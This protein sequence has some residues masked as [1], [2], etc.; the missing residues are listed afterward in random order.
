MR[1]GM[2]KFTSYTNRLKKLPQKRA[3]FFQ[4]VASVEIRDLRMPA[5]GNYVRTDRKLTGKIFDPSLPAI[6]TSD[7]KTIRFSRP[8]NQV[9]TIAK[10]LLEDDEATPGEVGE[11]CFDRVMRTLERK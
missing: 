5:R 9:E 6:S 4:G 1:E 10:R 3:E 8:A 7:L 2:K 11:F